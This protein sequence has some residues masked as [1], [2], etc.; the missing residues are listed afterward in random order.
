[1]LYKRA[2]GCS[3]TS[4]PC[5]NEENF[6]TYVEIERILRDERYTGKNVYGKQ[7]RQTVGDW[8]TV[9]TSKSDW[10]TVDGTHEGIVTREEFDRAQA[11]MREYRERD[12]L[13]FEDRALRRKVRCGVCGHVMVRSHR[14]HHCYS[15]RTPRVTDAYSCPTERI[16]E[17]DIME[18]LLDGLHVLAATAVEWSRIWKEEQ[19]KRQRDTT[20]IWRTVAALKETREQQEQQIRDLYESFALGE[21][22]KAE[23][24]AAKA[25]MLQKRDSV[26]GRIAELEAELENTGVDG[27]LDNRFVASFQ[28]YAG[29][30]EITSEI[31][32]D[33]LK[34]ILVYPDRRIEIVWNY[35]EEFEKLLLDLHGRRKLE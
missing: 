11:A 12:G 13:H 28:K 2:A 18:A 24:L 7:I 22:G 30:E 8:H 19:E 27:C 9:R 34:E 20:A 14:K 23:Y 15:C 17:C 32:E 33:V 5:I 35:Q 26:A 25:A 4:W 29:I 10:I 21:I 6:W 1:M 16:P 3:R 31:A